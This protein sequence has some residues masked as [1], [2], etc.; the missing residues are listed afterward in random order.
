MSLEVALP[1][2]FI[3]YISLEKTSDDKLAHLPVLVLVYVIVTAPL[4]EAT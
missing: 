3:T 4:T 2:G 1:L